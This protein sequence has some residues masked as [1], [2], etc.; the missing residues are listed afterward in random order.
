MVDD[1][2]VD[3]WA[4]VVVAFLF[5]PFMFF[6]AISLATVFG[7]IGGWFIGLFF[8]NTILGI[9]SQLGVH[10]VAMWQFGAFLGFV[11]GFFKTSVTK[12]ANKALA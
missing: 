6:F 9:L 8:G 2:T 10:N 1:K 4:K 11:G 7:A 12:E 5:V 3:A